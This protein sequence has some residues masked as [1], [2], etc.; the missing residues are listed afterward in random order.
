MSTIWYLRRVG[1]KERFWM[2]G[3]NYHQFFGFSL[4]FLAGSG[5][6]IEEA[7]CKDRKFRGR[8]RSGVVGGGDEDVWRREGKRDQLRLPQSPFYKQMGALLLYN[9]L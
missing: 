9:E 3:S 5:L 1:L 4:I 8:E 7:K 6:R 2:V